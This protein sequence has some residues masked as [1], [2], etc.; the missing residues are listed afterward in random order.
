VDEV[1]TREREV[2]DREGNRL[3]LRVRP[4]KNLDNKIDGAVLAVF[5]TEAAHRQSE[6]QAA[7]DY[8]DAMLEL[9]HEPLLVLDVHLR[10]RKANAPF[11]Q[12]FRVAPGETEGRMVYELGNGQWNIPKLRSLLEKV[13]T[14]NEQITG[15]DVEHTFPGI[16]RK[17]MRL[18]ARRVDHG[19]RDV[20]RILLA[21][22]DVTN[23][24]RSERRKP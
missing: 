14:A 11:L 8:A 20:D 4:Y 3:S 16:G 21:I 2:T 15:Y 12:M 5:D 23:D 1:S 22:A 13:L 7:W 24:V 10:V 19:D 9:L 17:K 6:A 18:N